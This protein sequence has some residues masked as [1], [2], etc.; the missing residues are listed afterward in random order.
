MNR[1]KLSRKRTLREVFKERR[2][3]GRGKGKQ[4]ESRGGRLKRK[5]R[6][7]ATSVV[8]R[9]LK[10]TEKRSAMQSGRGGEGR[11]TKSERKKLK[12]REIR[13]ARSDREDKAEG[14]TEK[15]RSAASSSSL[16]LRHGPRKPTSS[17]REQASREGWDG[18]ERKIRP[19]LGPGILFRHFLDFS[20]A[21][22]LCSRDSQP[23]STAAAHCYPALVCS[24]PGCARRA[25]NIECRG[26][27]RNG[28]TRE[29][30]SLQRRWIRGRTSS[31]VALELL[32]CFW[33]RGE[34]NMQEN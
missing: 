23:L 3:R 11:G 5:R 9:R 33:G 10:R 12:G 15:I 6:S 30:L 28:A 4:K 7:S 1:R 29:K 13:G 19:I 26:P 20:S 24:R 16:I 14:E 27:F 32:F 22:T 21:A 8:E 17:L 31:R 25:L 2:Q 34:K 18:G